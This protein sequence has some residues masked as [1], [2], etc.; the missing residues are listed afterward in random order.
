LTLDKNGVGFIKVALSD[1]AF[2]IVARKYVL[3]LLL[4]LQLAVPSVF[5]LSVHSIPLLVPFSPLPW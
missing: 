1:I 3:A 2:D 4:G 5:S